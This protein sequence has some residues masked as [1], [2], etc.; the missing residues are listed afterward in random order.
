MLGK[1]TRQ[2][3]V[4]LCT[5]VLVSGT[6][7]VASASPA[8]AASDPGDAYGWGVNTRGAVGDG[9]TTN[10][11]VPVAVCAPGA[12]APCAS[13][14]DDAVQV[15][16]SSSAEHSVALLS[17]GSVYAWGRNDVGSVG[18]GTTTDRTVPVPVC[19]VGQSAPCT[20]FL[21]DA[22]AV[23]AG[24]NS[25][26]A[27]LSDGTVVAW[28][29]NGDG[30]LGD[31]TTTNRSVPV[32]VCAVG[33]SAPCSV[34]L[35][36]VASI[37]IGARHSVALLDDNTAVAWGFNAL[38]QLGDNTTTSRSVPVAVCD[39]AVCSGQLTVEAIDAGGFHTLAL[40]DDT[41]VLAWGL[42]VDGQLGDSTT[43]SRS[44]PATVCAV[45]GCAGP[46]LGVTQI[47]GGG[48]SSYAVL[49]DGTMVS[50]GDNGT[51]QLGNGTTTSTNLPVS[52]CAVGQ[53]APCANPLMGVN[54]IAG[55]GF[56]A[57]ARIDDTLVAWGENTLGGQLGDGTTTSRSVPVRVCA[58]GQTAPCSQFIDN[59]GTI[60]IGNV[61][62]LAIR[63]SPPPPADEADL[64][65]SLSAAGVFL[66]SKIDYTL[67]VTNNGPDA[68][69][70]ATIVTQVP[71]TTTSVANLGT[72][73][74]N[75][76]LK[77]VSC[78]VGTLASSASTNFT[79][80][81]TI[82]LLTVGLP[83]HAEAQR[84][85]SIP[86]DPNPANDTDPA[87][88]LVITGLIILC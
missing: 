23:A 84:T 58:P 41:A 87:N 3:T 1:R 33:Q 76:T 45:A 65:V 62:S 77:Q 56:H 31:G 66:Q 25:S 19:A 49:T 79:F 74:Y 34:F 2:L 57:L 73:S 44:T 85:L 61:H 43:T 36:D 35:D 4:G 39:D 14:L 26:M 17:D 28:G 75:N 12:T 11:S 22:V 72:C 40:G 20:V 16:S 52:V 29:A 30:Q 55:G 5:A 18:D 24:S 63:V 59:V 69:T 81:A 42:N 10:R 27:L 32:R 67:G 60:G 54:E 71:P 70:S 13:V 64:A 47:S 82:G 51:G 37:D 68:L 6:I 7:L 80:R 53:T 78:P 46:L 48:R 83:L 15:S 86:N 88:C 21:D 38:G 8:A 50:W 9:S